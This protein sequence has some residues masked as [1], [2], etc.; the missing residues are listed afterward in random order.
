MRQRTNIYLDDRQIAGLRGVADRR[1][2]TVAAL[3]REAVD[4]W[5]ARNGVQ[6]VGADEWSRR[7]DALLSR[8][9]EAARAGGWGQEEVDREVAQAVNEVRRARTARRR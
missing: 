4:D 9:E 1:G 5:L 3:V 6:P 2:V 7:F 8:R